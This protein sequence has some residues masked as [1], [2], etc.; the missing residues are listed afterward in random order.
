MNWTPQT[1]DTL[2]TMWLWGHSSNT[3]AATLGFPSRNA[4]MGK[5]NRLGLMKRGGDY[6]GARLIGAKIDMVVVETE[7]ADLTGS[8]FDWADRMDRTLMV[9]MISLFVG[10]DARSVAAAIDHPV[11]EVAEILVAMDSTG[12]W[13]FGERPP[14]IWWNDKEGNMAFLL[15]AMVTA[16]LIAFDQRG[17]ERL[18]RKTKDTDEV[19]VLARLSRHTHPERLT[20]AA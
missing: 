16:G 1:I 11:S 2:E 14:A 9:Q 8:A 17:K 20:E 19:Q 3:I 7:L 18:Y 13:K 12:S 4:V 5:L 15:D 6:L 10:Q